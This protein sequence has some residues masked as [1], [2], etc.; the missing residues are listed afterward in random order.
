[1]TEKSNQKDQ[2]EEWNLEGFIPGPN[3]TEEAF[4]QRVEFCQ[5]LQHHLQH[6]Q[7]SPLPFEEGAD[8]NE[9]ILKE[10]FSHSFRLYGIQPGWVPI[11]FNNFHLAPWHGGCAWIFQ[12]NDQ[13]P[14]AALLQLRASF[15]HSSNFMRIYLRTELI[16]HELSHVGRMLYHEPQFEEF[17]AYQSSSS[18]WGRRLGPIIQSSRESLIFI[19]LLGLVI[20][21]DFAAL[22]SPSHIHVNIWWLMILPLGCIAF[23]VTRLFYR[24]L[25]FNRSLHNLKKLYSSEKAR[26]LHYRL[27]DD[28]IRKF[29]K[30]DSSRIKNYILDQNSFRWV[31]LKTIYPLK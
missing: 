9:G 12:L 31:V 11:F 25:L 23:A 13:S 30:W 29:S 24:H 15:R 21:A 2:W 1:M 3:E 19:I 16:T 26:H 10:A 6:S 7:N 20:L 5:N 27:C 28:E 18:P 22:L 17:F 8:K 14:I 4:C